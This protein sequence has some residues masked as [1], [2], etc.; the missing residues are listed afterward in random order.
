METPESKAKEL[1]FMYSHEVRGLFFKKFRI[2]RCAIIHC[3]GMLDEIPMY[4]GELN[5]RWKFWQ[6]VKTVLESNKQ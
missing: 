1:Y 5:P 2:K 4:I 6:S 3:E